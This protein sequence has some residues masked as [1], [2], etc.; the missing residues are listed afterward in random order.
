MIEHQ[1]TDIALEANIGDSVLKR[2][3]RLIDDQLSSIDSYPGD[4]IRNLHLIGHQGTVR[5]AE[6]LQVL[7]RFGIISQLGQVDRAEGLRGGRQLLDHVHVRVEGT[8]FRGLL[9]RFLGVDFDLF[10]HI[11]R[12]RRRRLV[13]Y[14]DGRGGLKV[15]GGEH[16]WPGEGPRRL[17]FRS[18]FG[19]WSAEEKRLENQPEEQI[20]LL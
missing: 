18:F 3:N 20:F 15:V 7:H 5:V 10:V 1:T 12:R 2:S 8:E 13:L 9:R 19:T 4:P 6:R 17:N 16:D 11:G 14:T